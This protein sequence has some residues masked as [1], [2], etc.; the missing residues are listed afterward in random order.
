MSSE[1]ITRND[2]K[3]ILNELFPIFYPIGSYYETSDMSFNPNTAWGGTWVLDTEY[4][5]VAWAVVSNNTLVAS[6][7][8]QSIT[9]LG[10]TSANVITF[11]EP[12]INANYLVAASGEASGIGAE[13]LGVYGKSANSFSFDHA[14]N[15]GTAVVLSYFTIAV[16]GRLVN[17]EKNKW[18]RT[19]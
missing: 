8:I 6:K 7:N 13:I 1:V 9:N 11:I 5:L 12:M 3:N 14:N 18:H 17:A 15:A 4:T 19:A 16:F 2:L 10:T